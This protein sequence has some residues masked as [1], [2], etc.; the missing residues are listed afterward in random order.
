MGFPT[1]YGGTGLSYQPFWSC[2][3]LLWDAITIQT[4]RSLIAVWKSSPLTLLLFI[5]DEETEQIVEGQTDKYRGMERAIGNRSIVLVG[6]SDGIRKFAG[7]FSN[8]QAKVTG[9]WW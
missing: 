7:G 3:I 8:S 1:S 5:A 6:E 2:S 4:T 9:C